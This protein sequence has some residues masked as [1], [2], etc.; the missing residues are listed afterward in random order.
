MVETFEDFDTNSFKSVVI[1][2]LC[3]NNEIVALLDKEFIDAG[4]GLL[5]NRIFPFLRHPQTIEDT[6]P[7]ICIKVDHIRNRNHFIETIDV[8]IY[9]VCHERELLKKVQDYKTGH[10]KS[11]TLI[12]I[13]AEEIKKTLVGLDTNWIGKLKL[14]SNTED[15]LNYEYPYRL[16]TFTAM[17][18]SYA[19]YE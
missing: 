16:L 13:L 2:E 19:H 11:G 9:I 10:I 7:F 12:D 18:E 4:G 3:G 17:K 14:Y 15:V 6:S 1:N 8:L 5:N